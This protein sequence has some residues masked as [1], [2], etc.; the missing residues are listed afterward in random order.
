MAKRIRKE[1]RVLLSAFAVCFIGIVVTLF[2]WVGGADFLPKFDYSDPD[3]GN[4]KAEAD[5]SGG[6]ALPPLVYLSDA[7]PHWEIKRGK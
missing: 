7:Y 5:Q 2:I 3:P 6:I 1:D 4:S